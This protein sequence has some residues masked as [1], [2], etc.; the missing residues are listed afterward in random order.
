M[1]GKSHPVILRQVFVVN[2]K[3]AGCKSITLPPLRGWKPVH[4]L[5][6]GAP[7]IKYKLKDEICSQD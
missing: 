7:V 3:F 2:L 4:P 1:V 5:A 6:K